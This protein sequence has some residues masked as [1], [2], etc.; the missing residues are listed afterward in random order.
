MSIATLDSIPKGTEQ[1]AGLHWIHS[2]YIF[3]MGKRD[4]EHQGL[5]SLHIHYLSFISLPPAN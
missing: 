4:P 1:A 2:D 5:T 3:S